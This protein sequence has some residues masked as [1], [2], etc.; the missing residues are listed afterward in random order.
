MERGMKDKEIDRG[1]DEERE[2]GLEGGRDAG[3]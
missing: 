2:Q 3:I 1:R